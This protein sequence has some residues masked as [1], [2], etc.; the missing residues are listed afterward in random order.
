MS[1]RRRKT[2]QTPR[3]LVEFLVARYEMH[4][5]ADAVLLI[6]DEVAGGRL[7]EECGAGPG[8]HCEA[9]QES[10]AVDLPPHIDTSDQPLPGPA[11]STLRPDPQA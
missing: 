10:S 9:T 6:L 7:A 5:V 4:E 3:E 11:K 1:A 2:E 8:G